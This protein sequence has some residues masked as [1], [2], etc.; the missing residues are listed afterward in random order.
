MVGCTRLPAGPFV[1]PTDAPSDWPRRASKTHEGRNPRPAIP[2]IFDR[3]V[4]LGFE[5]FLGLEHHK[6]N[7]QTSDNLFKHFEDMIVFERFWTFFWCQVQF[8]LLNT[9]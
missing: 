1:Y 4:V 5:V 6:L 7:H 2:K 8:G 3:W 9:V